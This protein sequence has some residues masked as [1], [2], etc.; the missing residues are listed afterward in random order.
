MP[1]GFNI[2]TRGNGI[3]HRSVPDDSFPYITGYATQINMLNG[4]R[5]L[6]RDLMDIVN[7]DY[8]YTHYPHEIRDDE[9][10]FDSL[11][12]G[13]V[14]TI[15]GGYGQYIVEFD[16]WNNEPGATYN[17]TK[18]IRDDALN[19]NVYITD[20]NYNLFHDAAVSFDIR[21]INKGEWFHHLDGSFTLTGNYNPNIEG[22]LSG[23]TDHIK[24]ELMVQVLKMNKPVCKNDIQFNVCFEY[25]VKDT[26]IDFD[27]SETNK[28]KLNFPCSI[29]L[30]NKNIEQEVEKHGN[31]RGI[32]SGKFE[33]L[34]IINNNFPTTIM[35]VKN[36]LTLYDKY[37][38]NGDMYNCYLPK[39]VYDFEI[40]INGVKNE[41]HQVNVC[42]G[43]EPFYNVVNWSLVHQIYDDTLV[44]LDKKN[45]SRM[46]FGTIYDQY[47]YPVSGVEIIITSYN[48]LLMYCKTNEYGRYR[49]VLPRFCDYPNVNI[50]IRS[51]DHTVKIIENFK[52][53]PEM[54]FIKQLQ[55]SN[56]Q[57]IHGFNFKEV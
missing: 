9:L 41:F 31:N 10:N 28:V 23:R 48:K 53:N 38:F 11:D 54:G 30:T 52:Y 22:L 33:G 47:N 56:N 27:G 17:F 18:I 42:P 32:Y 45:R 51:K 14:N 36:G 35:N 15:F 3:K 39:G 21:D 20:S 12:F 1:C 6:E 25:E 26:I 7:R 34:Q 8:K 44:L 4:E 5:L 50:R 29:Q 19:C 49:F 37:I 57:F 13:I 2:N 55:D 40:I 16:I 46:V 43:I 24:F